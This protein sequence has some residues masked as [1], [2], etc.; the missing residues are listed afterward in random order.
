MSGRD[1][2]G[3]FAPGNQIAVGNKGNRNPKWGNKNAVKHGFYEKLTIWTVDP[4]GWLNISVLK[5]APARIRIHPDDFFVDEE[6]VH[7]RLDIL[8]KLREM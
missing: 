8:E 2:L 6:G 7:I 5:G 4:G 1:K 3:R